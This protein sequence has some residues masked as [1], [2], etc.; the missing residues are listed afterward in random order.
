MIARG[1]NLSEDEI[2]LRLGRLD[3]EETKIHLYDY[4]IKNDDFEKTVKLI[5]AIIENESKI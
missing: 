2:D 1:D 3:Y 5:M 4:M